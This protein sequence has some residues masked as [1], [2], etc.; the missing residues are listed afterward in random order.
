MIS[1]LPAGLEAFQGGDFIM[2][3]LPTCVRID[4]LGEDYP[5]L[6]IDHPSCKA[7]V[8]FHGAHVME[9][10]PAGH[11]PVLYLSP[12]AL[13]EAGKPIRGGI[14]ICWPWF[15]P[16]PSDSAKPAHGFVRTRQWALVA[17]EDEGASVD[18]RFEL[19]SDDET[20]ASWPHAFEAI[21]EIRL[22]AELHVSLISH[23][24]AGLPFTETSALHT[25]L[26]VSEAAEISISGLDGAPF[27]ERAAG[28]NL[29]GVQS[30]DVRIDG[31]VD[32][33]YQSTGAVVLHDRDRRI[34]VHKHGSA[35]TVVWNPGPEKAAR[36]GD[37]PPGDFPRFVCIEAANAAGAEVTVAS[38]ATHV[39]RTRIVVEP[40]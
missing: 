12:A 40:V 29:S 19:H 9:W 30:G 18:L 5:I 34:H 36:L 20:L 28:Q 37:L 14:P 38:G 27:V 26:V 13:L 35:S 2:I 24:P 10:A 6:E 16:H 25:Y 21:L 1:A 39:L 22:G 32:R 4:S 31:E 11:S 23:N 8:A 7:R 33:I 17:C 3:P 15:G